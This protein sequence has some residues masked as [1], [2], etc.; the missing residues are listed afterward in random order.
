M[1]K[2]FS[3]KED[4]NSGEGDD[5]EDNVVKHLL[6]GERIEFFIYVG[7]LWVHGALVGAIGVGWL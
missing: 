1:S 5:D 4:G 3:P 2:K 6:I 7:K